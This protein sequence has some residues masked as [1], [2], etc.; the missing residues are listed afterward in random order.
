MSAILEG[1]KILDLT[2][3]IAGPMCTQIL[4]DMG[5]AVYK[6]EKPGEGDDTRRMGPFLQDPVT[7]QPS[8]DSALYLAYNRGKHSVTVDI[9]T[10]EGAQLV[11]ELALRCD[12]VVENYKVGSLAKYGL[13]EA[14]LRRLKPEL[15]YC[16]VTGFGQSG[17]YAPK[18]AY[19]FILQGLAGP[20]STC[21]LPDDQ[22]GGGPMR[23]AIPMTDMVT[24][25]YATIGILGALWHRQKTGEGQAI[26]AAMLDATVA[27]NGHLAVGYLMNGK[28]PQRVGNTNPIASPSEVFDCAD[29]LIVIAA[30]NNGQ[31]QKMCTVLGAPDMPAEPRFATNMQRIAHRS[32]L[33]DALQT[34]V[35][36]RSRAQLLQQLSDASV[37]AGPINDMAQ[38]FADPQ[39]QHRQMVVELPH[40]SGQNV[41]LVRSPLNLSASPVTHKAPP[42]L[43]EHSLQTLRE[44]LGL[45]DAQL[46]GLV[47][48]GVV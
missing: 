14:S 23:T 4:A 6:I 34:L 35:R 32:E 7:G 1:I 31:F 30:G 21:G 41:R 19:D 44:E 43:G 48:R 11:R 15:I 37:P 3:V 9:A 46:E 36:G 26:D 22:A 5:A 10:P 42:R 13:D 18:P 40:S 2:R 16:S 45:S 38:V 25:L 39:T 29:G 17:P 12:V 33:R 47:R 8:N 27:F 24:G 20:M 28:A